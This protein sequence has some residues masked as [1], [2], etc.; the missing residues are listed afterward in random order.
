MLAG[1][2]SSNDW[3][4]N[5]C[6]ISVA[7]SYRDTMIEGYFDQVVISSGSEVI[8]YH[9]S[10]FRR[11]DF[12]YD[13]I[14]YVPL[15]EQKTGALNQVAPLRGWELPEE[16]GALRRLLEAPMSRRSKREY[17]QVPRPLETSPQQQV[18][19]AIRLGALSFDAVKRLVPCQL[20]GRP[21]RLNLELSPYLPRVRCQRHVCQG[22][23]GPSVHEGRMGQRPTLLLENHL[24]ELKLPSFLREYRKMAAQRAAEGAD[25]SKYLLG[26]ADLELIERQRMVELRIWAARFPDVKSLPP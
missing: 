20:E 7:Y 1:I 16:F 11:E 9:P 17:V 8:A 14:H 5:D 23:Y 6:S 13:P 25:H 2:S 4:T 10:S 18:H 24:K 12:V 15:L 26:L 19:T 3:W 21:P 22:L